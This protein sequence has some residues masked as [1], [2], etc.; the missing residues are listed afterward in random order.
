MPALTNRL[1]F[2]HTVR[3]VIFAKI[4]QLSKKQLSLALTALNTK[5][6]KLLMVLGLITGTIVYRVISWAID[7][8]MCTIKPM[9]SLSRLDELELLDNDKE[10]ANILCYFR[11]P[12]TPSDKMKK[13][14]RDPFCE[15]VPKMK[16][17]MTEYFGHYYWHKMDESEFNKK[18]DSFLFREIQRV[19]TK[20]ELQD[21]I[22][23]MMTGELDLYNLPP[24][25]FTYI[26]EYGEEDNT[27]LLL[28]M[29]HHSFCDTIQFFGYLSLIH[30]NFNKES[31]IKLRGMPAWKVAVGNLVSPI[32][33][34]KVC[35]DI[36]LLPV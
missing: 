19:E 7:K 11:F 34:L 32:F 5:M 31:Q 35:L 12:K 13:W 36:L 10:T 27:S 21:I 4:C 1:L 33:F 3:V 16:V 29:V 28:C 18:F 17:K 30:D 23:E 22:L 8:F 14:I 9:Y 20:K 2:W 15:K 6:P 24:Y 26:E 25:R